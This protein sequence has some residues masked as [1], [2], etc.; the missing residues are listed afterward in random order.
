MQCTFVQI[1]DH[2]VRESEGVLTAGYSTSHALR[3]VLR[4]IADHVGDRADFLISTGD[5]V[6]APSDAAYQN[7]RQIVRARGA[8]ELALGHQV[9][10]LGQR[11]DVPM[12]F[13]PGNHDDRELFFRW[14]VP[15]APARPLFNY[16]FERGGVQFVALDWG[17]RS[18]AQMHP[19]TIGFLREALARGLPAV[20]F[21]HYHVVPTQIAW[22]D[23]LIA[24]DVHE[25]WPLLRGRPILGVFCGHAHCTYEAT[26]GGVPIFGL[27][28]TAP[29]FAPQPTPLLCLQPP[30]YRLVRIQDGMLTTRIFEVPL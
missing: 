17:P 29:Q 7:F 24:D 27:R 6:E 26:V 30:H 25:L 11:A 14:M 9:V 5:L 13:V 21:M 12:Y 20:L 22:L 4:H 18:K 28:S 19:E 3:A 2:H 1:S 8:P 15:G 16:A 10:A 23:A